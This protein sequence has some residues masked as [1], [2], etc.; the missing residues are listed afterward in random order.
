MTRRWLPGIFAGIILALFSLYPQFHLRELRGA[1]FAG[2]FASCDLDEMAYAAYMQALIDGRPRKSDPYTGRDSTPEDPQAESLF[3]IQFVPAY[4]AAI[5]A[6]ILGLSASE[7]MPVVSAVSAFFTA[8]ALF[9]LVL[10]FT[11]DPDAAFAGTLVVLFGGALVSGIG[12]INGF[13]EGGAA[14]PFIPFLRRPIPSLAFPFLFAFFACIWNGLAAVDRRR[15]A[16]YAIAAMLCFSVLVFSYFYLWTS[17]A[18][19]LAGAIIAA[20]A[21]SGE[22]RRRDA[23]YLLAI[24]ALCAIPLVPYAVLLGGRNKMADQAQLLV[25]T[26]Q[27]DLWRYVEIVGAAVIVMTAAV[28]L[29]RLSAV[30]RRQGAMILALALSPILVFNQQVLTGHSLQPFHYEFY[31]INYVVLAAA[32]LFLGALWRRYVGEH[33]TISTAALMAIAA[34]AAIWGYVEVTHTTVFWDDINIQRDQAMAVDLR[35][36]ELAGQNIDSAKSETTLNLESLQADGQPTVAPQSVLWARHQNTFAGLHSIEESRDRYYKL[37]Y[38]SGADGEWLRKALTGCRDIEACMAL[39]GWDRFNARLSANA[40]PL[41]KPEID[42]E[43][44]KFSG[45]VKEFDLVD[46]EEPRLSYLIVYES[47]RDTLQ[48]VEKWYDLDAGERLGEYRLYKLKLR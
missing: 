10:S 16:I 48:N 14:Y 44:R 32:V 12:A 1:E 11:E 4:M 35:L 25:L 33:R 37:L 31:V 9:W 45:F 7:M 28:L 3:S 41:T 26:H 19:V 23:V 17:A 36:R 6:R 40:R 29:M 43:V 13:F 30:T 24:S 34:V 46:A 8:L 47:S 2:A 39:F 21:V 42:D 27:P 22:T 18:A 5:P 38:Y 20:L 15:R